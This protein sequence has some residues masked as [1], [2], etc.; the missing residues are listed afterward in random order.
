MARHVA[1]SQLMMKCCVTLNLQGATNILLTWLKNTPRNKAYGAPK[2]KWQAI[3]T[4]YILICTLLY[5]QFQDQNVRRIKSS[6]LKQN[7]LSTKCSQKALAR[8]HKTVQVTWLR[9]VETLPRKTALKRWIN[10][11]PL[12]EQIMTLVM[13]MLLLPRLQAVPTHR[14]HLF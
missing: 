14:T 5:P 13:A 7:L 10:A 12:T 6:L 4:H 1:S 9:K 3:Q 2:A 11:L 8:T